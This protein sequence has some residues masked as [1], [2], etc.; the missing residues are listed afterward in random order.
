MS[1]DTQKGANYA[2][3]AV[4]E[5]MNMG[6]PYMSQAFSYLTE[7]SKKLNNPNIT[8]FAT[9]FSEQTL[10]LK[11]RTDAID[12]L[13]L[14]N[15]DD[16]PATAWYGHRKFAENLVRFLNPKVIVDLGV[17]WGY[18]TFSF[19]IPRIGHTYGIDNFVGDDFVGTDELRKKYDFVMM[20]REKLHLQ[21]NLS[22]KYLN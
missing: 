19:A 15:L 14:T 10:V 3:H 9:G 16:T 6:E 4:S 8:V 1:G 21:D 17:D 22:Q 2:F 13:F 20:K 18:S 5:A 7:I 12:K 11:E